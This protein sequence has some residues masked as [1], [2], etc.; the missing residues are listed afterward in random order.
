LQLAL[1]SAAL[2]TIENPQGHPY[3]LRV[4]ITSEHKSGDYHAFAA[5]LVAHDNSLELA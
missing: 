1:L 3:E 2:S 4:R 5:Q